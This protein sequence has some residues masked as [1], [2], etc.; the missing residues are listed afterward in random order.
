MILKTAFLLISSITFCFL[1]YNDTASL[2][3]NFNTPNHK[4]TVYTLVEE[5]P[6]ILDCENQDDKYRCRDEKV[7]GFI[8]E[9]LDYS[10]LHLSDA[11]VTGSLVIVSFIIDKKGKMVNADIL[12]DTLPAEFGFGEEAKRVIELMGEEMDW[13]ADR[14]DGQA[15]DVMLKLPVKFCFR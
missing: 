15:V 10:N 11:C 3:D 6:Y 7:I 9:N 8:Y 5:M 13:A 1:P 14:Q 4:D 12:R 2:S